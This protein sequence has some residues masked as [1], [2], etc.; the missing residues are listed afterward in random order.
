[1]KVLYLLNFAGKAGT[2]RYVETLVKYLS[3]DGRVEPYFA[4]NEGGLLVERLEAMG[5]PTRQIT[6]S[7]RFDFRAARELAGLCG[8]WGIELIHCHYLRENYIAML[9]KRYNRKIR[10]VYTNHFVL[11]NDAVTRL[12]NRW[13]DKQQDQMIAV[14]NKGKEQLMANGWSGGHIQVIFN[15]VDSDAW[16]GD[17]SESTLRAELG[18]P[19]DR[20]VMLCASRFADDKGHAYLIRSLKRLAE[21][22]DRPFTMV[23]AGDGP[24]LEPTKALAQELGLTGD[25]VKFIGFRKDIKNLYKA[26]DLYINSSQHEALSFLIVEAMAAGLPAVITD[27]GGNSDIIKTPAD[28]GLLVTYDDPDSMAEAMKRFLEDPAFRENCKVNA[29]ANVEARFEIHKMAAAT[30]QVYEKAVNG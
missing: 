4:Y 25:Q 12:S 16:A 7:S 24:L 1:M 20:F 19:D 21:R 17:R 30:F 13:L 14:C 18:I 6:L 28:G 23:L 27:M 5:V 26:S 3:A 29:L 9:A 8:E 15:A 10:V 11:A 2:E 22:S